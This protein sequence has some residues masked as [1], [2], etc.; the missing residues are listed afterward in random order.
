MKLP[1]LSRPLVAALCGLSLA[2]TV[3]A[4]ERE[5]AREER[6]REERPREE[7]PVEGQRPPRGDFRPDERRREEARD[8]EVR[9]EKLARETEQVRA[10]LAADETRYTEQIDSEIRLR[11]E[12]IKHEARLRQMADLGIFA[13]V[14]AEIEAE[15]ACADD[16]LR[17]WSSLP[18]AAKL[19]EL[20]D[21]LRSQVA[22]LQR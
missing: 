22:S 16:A 2:G 10:D 6:P 5:R 12:R 19:A 4:Q 20:R 13:A 8:A 9:R 7:R 1:Q 18:C 14:A 21:V 3:P 11:E 17:P 15:L